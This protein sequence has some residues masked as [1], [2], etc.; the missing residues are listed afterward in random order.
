[1]PS[2]PS[3]AICRQGWNKTY[4]TMKIWIFLDGRQQGPMDIDQLAQLPV[5]PTTPVWYE[6]LP[7][8][9]TLGAAPATAGLFAPPPVPQGNAGDNN[10]EASDSATPQSVATAY[11]PA[12]QAAT[13]QSPRQAGGI[14]ACPPNYL[15]WAILST[16]CCCTPVGIVA[17][18]YTSQVMSR[19][20]RGDYAGA[21]MASQRAQLWLIL[22]FV[23]G[24]IAVPF[25]FLMGLF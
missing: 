15:V 5:T 6:G 14:P 1:M 2:L 11:T 17:I 19:Y 12:P 23:L 10:A 24:L 20:N 16:I 9:S 13:A 21:L 4:N 3:D 22:A 25:M 8:W 7:D 18:V